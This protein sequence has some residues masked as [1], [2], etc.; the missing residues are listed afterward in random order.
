MPFA[1][2]KNSDHRLNNKFCLLSFYVNL[3]QS[4]CPQFGNYNSSDC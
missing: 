1:V 3:E 2:A 4:L